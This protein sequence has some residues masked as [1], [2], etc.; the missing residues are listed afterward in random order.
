MRKT[1]ERDGERKERGVEREIQRRPPGTIDKSKIVITRNDSNDNEDGGDG[2]DD[3]DD[4]DHEVDVNVVR[5]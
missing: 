5:E 2:G 1:G 3:D 4:D